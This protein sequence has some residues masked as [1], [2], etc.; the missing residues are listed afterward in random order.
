MDQLDF[1]AVCEAATRGPSALSAELEPVLGPARVFL[2][3]TLETIAE[4]H[5]AGAADI[6]VGAWDRWDAILD[7]PLVERWAVGAA[8]H[9]PLEPLVEFLRR[10]PEECARRPLS[11]VAVALYRDV[12]SAARVLE[13]IAP[14]AQRTRVVT[15]LEIG[16]L[17]SEKERR[18]ATLVRQ[19]GKCS[20][21]REGRWALAATLESLSILTSVPPTHAAV[22]VAIDCLLGLQKKLVG[23][24][25]DSCQ[26]L[27]DA[28]ELCAG[29]A[30]AAEPQWLEHAGVVEQKIFGSTS[31]SHAR[32]VIERARQ[33]IEDTGERAWAS[34]PPA[35]RNA[36]A[37]TPAHVAS[38][39][40]DSPESRALRARKASL[41]ALLAHEDGD[42]DAALEAV[43]LAAP[44]F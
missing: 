15:E 10:A 1:D 37:L 28:V 9:V 27:A 34:P 39:P 8:G 23:R 21:L 43:R 36:Q 13:A 30:S 18:L 35:G 33:R 20:N 7:V 44:A 5:G 6:D 3:V 12:A 29:A 32:R 31:G 22:A 11:R 24:R 25:M 17:R 42:R 2:T 41:L 19:A 16:V 26:R 38:L 4:A 40:V 14:D